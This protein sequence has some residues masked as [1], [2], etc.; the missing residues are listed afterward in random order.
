MQQVAESGGRAFLDGIEAMRPEVE[1]PDP[2]GVE[3]PDPVGV[4]DSGPAGVE[5]PDPAWKVKPEA[6]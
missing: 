3:D 6:A 2:A 5:D 4:E 1:D